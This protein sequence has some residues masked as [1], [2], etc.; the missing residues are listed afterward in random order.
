MSN[1]LTSSQENEREA[2]LLDRDA[3]IRVVSD[4]RL[5]RAAA[6]R[7]ISVRWGDG[8][9]DGA[10]IHAFASQVEDIEDGENPDIPEPMEPF[11]SK[12]GM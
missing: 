1:P 8:A 12:R 7:L 5:Y 4:L 2:L 6:K 9:C 11:V 10:C 3:V